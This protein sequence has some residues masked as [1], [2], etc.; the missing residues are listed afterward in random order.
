MPSLSSSISHVSLLLRSPQILDLT[1]SL[2][3]GRRGRAAC[4]DFGPCIDVCGNVVQVTATDLR[5]D[6][7]SDKVL[8]TVREEVRKYHVKLRLEE[9][10]KAEAEKAAK[11]QQVF[12]LDCML[13][14]TGC[15]S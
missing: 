8:K 11:K 1:L 9:Q 2:A 15:A 12:S 14:D 10:R 7:A 3:D 6:S 13:R 5:R 4:S